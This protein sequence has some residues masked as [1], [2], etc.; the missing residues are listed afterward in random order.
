MATLATV[1]EF[2]MLLNKLAVAGSKVADT[3]VVAAEI[4]E[5][6]DSTPFVAS[7]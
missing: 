7:P 5:S 4:G 2:T 1:V 6:K 3:L